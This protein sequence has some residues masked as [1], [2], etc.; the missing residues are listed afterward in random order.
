MIHF[1]T[2]QTDG[3]VTHVLV[4]VEEF[5]RLTGEQPDIGPPTAEE[6]ANA[7]RMLEDPNTE[8]Y[9]ANDVLWEIVR[10]GL[11]SVRK[12]QGLTQEQLAA[13]L[14]VSQSHVSRMEKSL[15]GVTLRVL[16]RMAELLA[17]PPSENQGAA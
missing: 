2:V 17:T 9:D 1:P 13:A 5:K 4:P 3:I 7:V 15:D 14:G 12:E 6:V 10:T 16:R 11:G 8:W